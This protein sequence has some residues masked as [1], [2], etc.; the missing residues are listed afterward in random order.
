VDIQP[1]QAVN[2]GIEFRDINNAPL[3]QVSYDFIAKDASGP[4][5]QQFTN[6]YAQT[7]TSSQQVTFTS[8]GPKTILVTI[9]AVGSRPVGQ[10]IESADFNIVVAGAANATSAATGGAANAT[11][12]AT[13]GAANATSAATGGAA[14]ATNATMIGGAAI[15][16]GTNASDDVTTTVGDNQPSSNNPFDALTDSIQN[17]FGGGQ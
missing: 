10:L 4:I 9:N 15:E 17:L 11:S 12:A 5:I 16:N 14:N 3:N 8:P 2:F 6:Q 13:G 1:N 7:G